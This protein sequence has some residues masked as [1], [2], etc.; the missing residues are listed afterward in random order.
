VY[1]ADL[2]APGG[3][4]VNGRRIRWARLASN[5][6]LAVGPF[7]FHVEIEE[8]SVWRGPEEPSFS[9]RNDSVVGVVSSIDPILLIGSD[10]GCDA[11]LRHS[12]VAPRHSLVI[13][14]D[15]GPVVRDLQRQENTRLNGRRVNFGRL[16]SGDSIG[17]GPFEFVFEAHTNGQ[18]A[19][20]GRDIRVA[21]L[22]DRETYH[23]ISALLAG[24]LSGEELG[25]SDLLTLDAEVGVGELTDD[26]DVGLEGVEVMRAGKAEMSQANLCES[27][28]RA[29]AEDGGEP[30]RSTDEPEESVDQAEADTSDMGDREM[31][32][33]KSA[34]SCA[35]DERSRKLEERYAALRARV[36]AAQQALDL[37]ARRIKEGLSGERDYLRSCRAELQKQ[38]ERLLD[39]AK[40]KQRR[41]EDGASADDAAFAAPIGMTRDEEAGE[42]NAGIGEAGDF[43]TAPYAGRSGYEAEKKA[44]AGPLSEQIGDVDWS[45]VTWQARARELAEMV[46]TGR[47]ELDC[48]Q[49]RL[50]DLRIEIRRL[51]GLVM[52]NRHRHQKRDKELEARLAALESAHAG[53]REEREKLTARLQR[54][55]VKEQAIQSQMKEAAGFRQEIAREAEELAEAQRRL[56]ERQQ[57]FR[58]SI[59][60]ERLRLRTRQAE[61]RRKTAELAQ[62]ARA[63]RFSVEEQMATQQAD[64]ERREAEL[65]ARRIAVQEDSCGEL[66]KTTAELEELLSTGLNELEADLEA[67]QAELEAQATV[68]LEEGDIASAEPRPAP[69]ADAGF[70]TGRG[71]GARSYVRSPIGSAGPINAEERTTESLTGLTEAADPAKDD[72]GGGGRLELLVREIEA[73]HGTLA[74]IEGQPLTWD[75]KGQPA[76][77]FEAMTSEGLRG[78]TRGGLRHTRLRATSMARV[79]EM[80]STLRGAPGQTQPGRNANGEPVL[81]EFESADDRGDL[82]APADDSIPQI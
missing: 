26:S 53:L 72:N 51:Q 3:T 31:S 73:L 59:E 25:L 2:A 45:D 66:Q 37:R 46:R 35:T 47:E 50:H 28:S 9:L 67:R 74:R 48:T 52:R 55:D 18:S 21:S 14:T 11:V 24:R 16:V 76:N 61:L 12:S 44:A 17:V 38:A 20:G 68:L 7:R 27:T 32:M 1:V 34:V 22:A 64:L 77:G 56:G 42:P 5:D 60:E 10:P 13:W 49:R 41:V 6:E 23:D 29:S 19:T 69:Y 4:T 15:E 75:V 71:D 54:V 80:S 62:A 57:T 33:T 43:D 58:S 65:Q 81:Y 79:R 78:E 40:N 8:S 82:T 39:T 36:A 63:R 70:G 30:H